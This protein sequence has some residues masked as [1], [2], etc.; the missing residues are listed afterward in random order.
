MATTQQSQASKVTP[1]NS[2]RQQED[3]THTPVHTP[4]HTPRDEWGELGAPPP[5]PQLIR[6]NAFD[7]NVFNVRCR[8]NF[9][10]MDMEYDNGLP[11]P[12][13]NEITQ[14]T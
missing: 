1:V 14:N 8:L 12:L 9:D 10:D 6:Q 3:V 4:V 2:P 13:G 7:T 11:L 5:P